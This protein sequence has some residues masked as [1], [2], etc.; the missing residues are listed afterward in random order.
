MVDDNYDEHYEVLMLALEMLQACI[1]AED[2]DFDPPAE[3]AAIA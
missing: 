2:P 1:D 3:A